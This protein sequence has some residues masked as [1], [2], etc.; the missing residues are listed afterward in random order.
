[1]RA[2]LLLGRALCLALATG[3]GAV[4]QAAAPPTYANPLDIEYRYNWEAGA[5]GLSYRAGADPVI[6]HGPDGYYLFETLAGG[7]WRSTDLAQWRFVTPARWPFEDMVAPAALFVGDT[8]F[9]MRSATAPQPI[10]FST[11]PATGRLEFYNR[12]LPPLPYAVLQ[13]T[14]RPG[15]LVSSDSVQPGPWDPALFRDD[16][17]RWFLYWGSSNVYPIYGIELDPTRRLA[18]RAGAHPV[19]LLTLHPD[20]HGWERFGQDHRDT[21][22][23][24][25][26][27][28]WMTRHDGRYYLQYAAPGTEYNV[29][30]NGTYVA[31]SPLGPFTYAPYNPISYRPGG[32]MVGAGHGNTFQDAFGN[33]WNTGTPWIGVNENWERRIALFPAGFEPD[34]QMFVDTRFGD[35]PHYAPT[36]RWADP[37]ELFTG[38]MLLS[39]HKPATASSVRDTFSAALATDENPRTFWV[40][41]GTGAGEWL[42]LDL[43]ALREVRALQVNFADYHSGLFESDSSV[44]TQFRI[45]ASTDGRAWQTIAELD[46]ERRDRPDAYI[47]LPRPVRARFVRY[48]HGHVGAVNLAISDLRV[49]GL[50]DGP[51]PRAPAGLVVRREPDARDALVAWKAVPGVVGYNVLWGIRPDRLHQ[52]YQ[53]FADQGTTLELRA[54]TLGQDYYVAVEAFDENGVSRRGATVHLP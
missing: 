46:G 42:Q 17:G 12:M 21:I 49:F 16:D 8:L 51:P 19:H 40:A 5:K 50:G 6:V 15:A 34:G 13:N 4:A 20:V 7:Y 9:L 37:A 35:F 53:R 41:A 22:R 14:E 11:A 38:W 23:P 44:Y 28:A 30:A 25:V 26:E 24:F 43:G 33:W 39:Y 45:L 31:D 27:G 48:A 32:F 29:Y 52:S 10:L 3:S 1:M 2:S 47:E 54:L 36:R 18:Y